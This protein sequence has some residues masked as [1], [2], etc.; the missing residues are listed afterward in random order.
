MHMTLSVNQIADL[1]NNTRIQLYGGEAITHQ[2][3]GLQAAWMAEKSDESNELVIACLLHDLGHMLLVQGNDD[4]AN[5]IDDQH[6]Q[7]IV[8]FLSGLLPAEVLDPIRWHVDAKRYLC[9][10]DGHYYA[11][12]SEA[13]KLSLTLQGGSMNL[14]QAQ[15]FISRPHAQATLALRRYDDAAKVRG[16]VVPAFEHYLPRLLA[17]ATLS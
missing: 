10:A 11:T 7:K 15:S 9:Y 2:Q 8:P 12:L 6:E 3:H 17:I 5:G 16:L 4:L 14:E 13:S 1:F